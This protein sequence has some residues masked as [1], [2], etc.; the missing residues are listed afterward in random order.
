VFLIERQQL[1]DVGLFVLVLN[2]RFY[3]I[4][5]FSNVL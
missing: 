5:V 1:V 2:G 3:R 4:A